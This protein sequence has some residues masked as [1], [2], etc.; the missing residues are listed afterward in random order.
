MPTPPAPIRILTVDDHELLRDGIAAVLEG[1]ADMTVV[2]EATNGL[3][4]VDR[5]RTL[6]PDVTLMDVQMP[7]MNGI[8]AIRTI[9]AEFPQARLIVLTTYDGDVLALR[10]LRAGAA[11]YLLKTMLRRHLID[12]IRA[13]HAGRKHIPGE[14]AVRMAEHQADDLLSDREIDV[15]QLVAAGQSN[16]EIAGEL[17]IAEETVKSHMKSIL[18]KLAVDDRTLAVTVAIKRGILAP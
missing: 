9:R 6:R 10:A 17:S 3:E 13:V 5:Y 11:G 12:A 16:K 18:G 8:D 4:A 15:L 14:I 2:G 1:E 7:E